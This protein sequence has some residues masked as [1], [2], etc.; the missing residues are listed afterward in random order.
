[1]VAGTK[2]VEPRVDIFVLMGLVIV[3]VDSA[4]AL[5]LRQVHPTAEEQMWSDNGTDDRLTGRATCGKL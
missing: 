2:D 5:S 4:L 1:M 3:L